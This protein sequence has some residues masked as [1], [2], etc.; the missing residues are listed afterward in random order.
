LAALKLFRRINFFRIPAMP[1]QHYKYYWVF[2]LSDLDG[3][4]GFL[5]NL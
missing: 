1:R 5:I 2:Y 4:V 3:I